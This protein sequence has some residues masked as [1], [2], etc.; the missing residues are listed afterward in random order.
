VRP[1]GARPRFGGLSLAQ[2]AREVYRRAG[3]HDILDRAAALSYYFLFALFPALLFLTT[4]LGL[5]PIGDLMG[6]LLRY[7]DEVLPP[8]VASLVRREL[9]AVT[10]G[11]RHSLLSLGAIGS[12]WGASRGAQSVIVALNIVYEVKTPRPWWRQQLASFA[13]T[14]AFALFIVGALLLLVFGERLGRVLALWVGLGSVFTAVWRLGQ[15][16]I[17]IAFVLLGLN[18]VYHLAPAVAPP[19]RW[20]SPGSAF[21]LGGWL[22]TSVGLRLYVSHVGDYSATYGSIG[23]VILLMLWLY[24]SGVTL[25]VGGLINAVIARA[26][27]GARGG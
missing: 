1:P 24:L 19:W 26:N 25:L 20:L 3:D 13:L 17:A 16:P 10:T 4:L 9:D 18:L 8:D 23:A 21:A 7:L 11:A 14:L 15:W 27:E 5:M 6:R 2:L 12:L 22:T